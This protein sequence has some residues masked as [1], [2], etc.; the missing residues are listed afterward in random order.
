MLHV[1][2]LGVNGRV[3]QRKSVPEAAVAMLPLAY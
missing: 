3:D 2:V 1:P